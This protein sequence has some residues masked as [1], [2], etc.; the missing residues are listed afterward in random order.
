MHLP[1]LLAPVLVLPALAA[2]GASL[3]Q[4]VVPAAGAA[5][6]R[7]KT[8]NPPSSLRAAL[9]ATWAHSMKTY[10]PQPDPLRFPNYGFH[11]VF[12][13]NGSISFCVRWDGKGVADAKLRSQVNAALKVQSKKWM[14]I[15]AGFDGW[16]FAEVKV[17]VVGWA[18]RD[19]ALAPGWSK[20]E[21]TLY[22]DRDPGGIPQCAERCGRF[23]HQDGNY[24]KCAGGKEGHYDQS[25][26]LT[27]GMNGGAGG[28]WGQRLGTEGFLSA[29]RKG[30]DIHIF[31]HEMG[32]TFGLADFYDW[33]PPGQTN[34]IMMAGSAMTITEFDAWMLRDW[35]RHLK[36]KILNAKVA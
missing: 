21:G 13:T 12:A 20:E 11:Q 33:R 31:L 17:Q 6:L 34:F 14:D 16:P 4:A 19:R 15:L 25:L 8:W 3:P 24:G 9:D 22:T 36:P 26:W 2:P 10:Q 23:F 30:G 27:D 7:E 1:L 28:D 29:M 32:H 35:W 18:V 5:S